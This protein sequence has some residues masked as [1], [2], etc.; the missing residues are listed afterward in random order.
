MIDHKSHERADSAKKLA[1]RL[2]IGRYG[3]NGF[4][5]QDVGKRFHL[6]SYREILGAERPYEEREHEEE[7]GG[8][9][10]SEMEIVEMC[11]GEFHVCRSLSWGVSAFP[12]NKSYSPVGNRVDSLV[13]E[14][15]QEQ[16]SLDH[17][18]VPERKVGRGMPD[19]LQ[20]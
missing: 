19:T 15:R 17:L 8:I 1:Y 4:V 3:K 18:A 16:G 14:Q 7:R 11:I 6:Q 9:E 5:N 12:Y 13:H 20:Q 10:T 2:Q